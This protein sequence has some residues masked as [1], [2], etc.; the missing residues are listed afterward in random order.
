[1]KTKYEIGGKVKRKNVQLLYPQFKTDEIFNSFVD[2]HIIINICLKLLFFSSKKN[3]VLFIK[4]IS[5]V[6]FI[7]NYF[8]L[9]RVR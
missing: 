9:K 1:M 7:L 4:Y 2:I 6:K 3:N 5:I 8:Y